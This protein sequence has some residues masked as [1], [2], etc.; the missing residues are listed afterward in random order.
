MTNH[1]SSTSDQPQP[2]HLTT[3]QHCPRP[4]SPHQPLAPS[5]TTEIIQSTISSIDRRTKIGPRPMTKTHHKR[6]T[7]NGSTLD[8][9]TCLTTHN[10]QS[11][12]NDHKRSA[13]IN[14]QMKWQM[15]RTVPSQRLPRQTSLFCSQHQ[16]D[17]SGQW[18][19]ALEYSH[20]DRV[21]FALTFLFAPPG[22]KK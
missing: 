16:T 14:R 22:Q 3:T 10:Q 17:P 7:I 21:L 20:P 13:I 6:P 19:E 2:N 12:I 5:L 4:C 9:H 11:I 8:R 18:M 15:Y 1:R